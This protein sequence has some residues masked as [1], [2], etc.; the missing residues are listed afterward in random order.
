MKAYIIHWCPRQYLQGTVEARVD[1]R[2]PPFCSWG[3]IGVAVVPTSMNFLVTVMLSMGWYIHIGDD[4]V[5]QIF[6]RYHFTL[7][8]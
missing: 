8:C 7:V 4:A 1:T 2:S 5:C 3:L 6:Y